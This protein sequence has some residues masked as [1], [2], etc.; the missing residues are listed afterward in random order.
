MQKTKEQIRPRLI[1]KVLFFL[2]LV[3][4]F[5]QG[6]YSQ[7][8]VR[9]RGMIRRQ[10]QPVASI[11]VTLAQSSTPDLRSTV[12]TGK[13]GMYYLY[14]PPGGYILAVWQSGS[15]P[16]WQNSINVGSGNFDVPVIVLP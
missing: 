7:E 4:I 2:V 14:A 9:I 16:V 15:T 11:R 6:L 12:Y 3:G 1:T 5:S 13:D 8:K 10:G